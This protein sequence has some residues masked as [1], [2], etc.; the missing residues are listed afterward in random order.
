MDTEQ[1]YF[2]LLIDVQRSTELAPA[3]VRGVMKRLEGE[4]RALRQ[5]L[6][7]QLA[8]G[9]TIS[10]GDEVAGLFFRV[11][12]LFNTV[13]AVRD[14]LRPDTSLRFVAAKGKIAVPSS[15]I[16]KVGGAVF[17]EAEEAMQRIKKKKRFCSWHVGNPE[18]DAV[19]NALTEMS[20]V[21]M[22]E[23]TDHQWK[24]FQLTRKGLSGKAAAE[25]LQKHPQSISDAIKRG[26][27]HLVLEAETAIGKV[28]KGIDQQEIMDS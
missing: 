7:Q 22:E 25:A 4:L 13:A 3:R 16:R 20:N 12:P 15:D 27:A 1:D 23:M 6:R 10:Y 11:A 28:L 5:R 19:L 17:K 8:L 14:V 26:K 2:L 24:V 21:F 9:L 18:Q